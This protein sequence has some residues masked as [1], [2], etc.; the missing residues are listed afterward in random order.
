MGISSID[1][2]NRKFKKTEFNKETEIS[3]YFNFDVSDFQI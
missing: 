3:L 1:N 2:E